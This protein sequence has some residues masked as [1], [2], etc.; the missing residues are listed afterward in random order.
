MHRNSLLDITTGTWPQ[1][2]AE[3]E[4]LY[5][6]IVD[7][8]LQGLLLLHEGRV[9]F[10]NRRAVQLLGFSIDE[11]RVCSSDDLLALVHEDDRDTLLGSVRSADDDAT[12]EVRVRRKDGVE[13]WFEV[14]P[15]VLDVGGRR[16]VQAAFLDVTERR[17]AID[18]ALDREQR[19][20]LLFDEARDAMFVHEP[21][22]DGSSGRIVEVNEAACRQLGY[23]RQQLLVMTMADLT[24]LDQA[25]TRDELDDMLRGRAL[26]FETELCA[27]DGRRI[28]FE[29]SARAFWYKGAPMLLS[30]ARDISERKAA[31]AALLEKDAALLQAQ[32]LE[33][34]GRLA[35]GIAH[36]FNNILGVILG[37][38]GVLEVSVAPGS[39]LRED[40]AE[41][42]R[43]AE[44]AAKLT[45]KLLAFSR[46]QPL[47]PTVVDINDVIG[48]TSRMLKRLIG[49]DIELVT[50]L[51]ADPGHVHV[52]RSSFEQ[53]IMNLAVNARDAM[54][55]GGKLTLE[56][57]SMQ[58]HEGPMTSSL[59]LAPGMYVV[60]T[61]TDTGCGIDPEVLPKIFEPFFTTKDRAV[62][63]GLGLWTVYGIVK[64]SGGAIAV[65]S[66]LG[67][68]TSFRIY[69]PECSEDSAPASCG[70]PAGVP[71]GSGRVLLAEDE[72][73]LRHVLARALQH[74]GYEVLEAG[75]GAE[76][77]RLFEEHD[78]RIDLLAT[79][80]IMPSLGGRDLAL[81]VRRRQ[82]DLPVLFMT[83]H[84]E[85]VDADEL[86][87][88]GRSALLLKPVSVKRLTRAVRDLLDGRP[89]S[90][91]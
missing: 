46:K 55:A 52:D 38:C 90:S 2:S 16:L 23:T 77:I 18:S 26:L 63:T 25:R 56:T 39:D 88:M 41:I 8:A 10:A 29:V 42:S 86:T 28:P 33:A 79:D 61:V 60:T 89:I 91:R 35:D 40:I 15:T 14:A 19:W 45:G 34:V 69:L 73:T 43:A 66:A 78:A 82:P 5:R 67:K 64:Q 48:D 81:A 6:S 36:D 62:G 72:H 4:L 58:L 70:Y 71:S 31:E 7:H 3:V 37:A 50:L 80:T 27:S 20:R 65:D 49:E 24:P 22:A 12:C 32:K 87:S 53:V 11:L 54:K 13:R 17:N 47:E 59:G 9:V 44:R 30:L 84:F 1:N 83:G 76:A 68:G 74:A 21:G 51:A 75:D 85:G 57:V